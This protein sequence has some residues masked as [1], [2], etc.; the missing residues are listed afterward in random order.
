MKSSSF[1]ALFQPR[2]RSPFAVHRSG[3]GVWGSCHMGGRSSAEPPSKE[4]KTRLA[5]G[6]PYRPQATENGLRVRSWVPL[7]SDF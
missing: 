1:G 6:S 5:G 3:F 7:P 2:P 4:V